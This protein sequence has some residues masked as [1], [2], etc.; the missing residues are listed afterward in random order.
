M[1]RAS[2]HQTTTTVGHT[3]HRRSASKKF[4][5][6]KCRAASASWAATLARPLLRRRSAFSKP[7]RALVMSPWWQAGGGG[8]EVELFNGQDRA[9]LAV[10]GH[11]VLSAGLTALRPKVLAN[12]ATSPTPA[13]NHQAARGAP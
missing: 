5:C 3:T 8:R 13:N 6:P 9:L 10:Q 1:Q 12:S 7:L 11:V 4:F 2:P